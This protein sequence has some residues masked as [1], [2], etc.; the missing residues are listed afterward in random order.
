MI[1][2]SRIGKSLVSLVA[3]GAVSVPA[4]SHASDNPALGRCVQLFVKEVV[5]VD[6][7]VDVRHDVILASTKAIS[8]TRSSVQ[9]IARGDKNSKLFGRASCVIDRNGS[10]VAMYLY[11]SKPGPMGASRPKVLAR[12]V[13][14]RVAYSDET[15]PF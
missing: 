12:N 7:S 15:K 6:H 14:A 4:A 11:D 2:N 13:D 3:L 1:M 10:I 8:E 5:P 9:L